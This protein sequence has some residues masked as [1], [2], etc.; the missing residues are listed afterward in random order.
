MTA[1]QPYIDAVNKWFDAKEGLSNYVVLPIDEYQMDPALLAVLNTA[2]KLTEKPPV[3]PSMPI[4]AIVK[5]TGAAVDPS[6]APLNVAI[7]LRATPP[8]GT[9]K[10]V[11]DPVGNA[12][13]DTNTMPGAWTQTTTL[14]SAGTYTS[15]SAATD[16]S[17][18]QIA[19]GLLV[20]TVAAIPPTPMP[21]TPTLASG[22]PTPSGTTPVGSLALATS[23]PATNASIT[24]R[25]KR[26][27]NDF[28][29]IVPKGVTITFEDC[30]WSVGFDGSYTK[31]S[32]GTKVYRGNPYCVDLTDN[33]LGGVVVFKRCH[34]TAFRSCAVVG[35]NYQAIGC[36]VDHS[37]GDGFK[38]DH[39]VLIQG[40]Y[41]TMLG[42]TDGAHADGVQIRD[43]YNIRIVGNFFN[44]PTDVPNTS[45]NAA[46]FLQLASHDVEFS[47]NWCIGGNYTV[48]AFP[49]ASPE[50]VKIIG[51][52]FY[53][54]TPR[55]G[56]GNVFDG[57]VW[58]GNVTADGKVATPQMK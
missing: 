41:V 11:F 51:N 10:V 28:K 6:N 24:I 32:D 43:G 25:N 27:T 2:D 55:Y 14:T 47:G 35:S 19:A 17:D 31:K 46:M 45:S 56:F 36:S 38:A 37:G 5:A 22:R 13:T 9:V 53:P 16:A 4:S 1:R 49:S 57:V 3:I 33:T 39:N 34:F 52:T 54:G 58:S 12:P 30:E 40:C 23:A 26:F 50:T 48:G 21:I 20:L 29:L 7:Q 18:K 15:M 8:A 44:M 42:M